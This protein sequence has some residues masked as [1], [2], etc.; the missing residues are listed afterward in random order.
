MRD[1]EGSRAH[2][3]KSEAKKGEKPSMAF[4]GL[5]RNRVAEGDTEDERTDRQME[6]GGGE[7]KARELRARNFCN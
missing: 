1:G 3:N 2:R 4:S 7:E 5:S 6:E